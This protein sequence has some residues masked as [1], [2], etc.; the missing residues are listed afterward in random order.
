LK[1]GGI[2]MEMQRTH[3]P[4]TLMTMLQ[5]EMP[6]HITP[7]ALTEAGVRPA[8]FIIDE[9]VGFCT[10]DAGNLAPKSGD[11]N[12]AAIAHMVERT[13]ELAE[14]LA[15]KGYPIWVFRDQHLPDVP[16][17]PYPP[18]CI[19]GTGEELLVPE[20]RWLHTCEHANVVPKRCISGF[21][22]HY[23][24]LISWVNYHQ[25]TH[26]VVVGICTDICN[27]DFVNP[28]LSARNTQIFPTLKEVIVYTE[29]CSTYNLPIDLCMPENQLN[30]WNAHPAAPMH[31]IGLKIMQDRGAQ[32]SSEIALR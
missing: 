10:P 23:N 9:V 14:R 30:A 3:P 29:A 19:I 13:N 20:L 22:A 11:P 31:Y 18:H 4:E 12:I 17:P 25:I 21:V 24:D 8:L 5:Q 2:D 27:T 32:L 1:Q 28:L 16:E 7:C 15:A 6:L 26:A